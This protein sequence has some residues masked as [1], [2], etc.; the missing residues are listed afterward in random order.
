MMT[1]PDGW[2][3]KERRDPDQPEPTGQRRHYRWNLFLDQLV[4]Q[5]IILAAL[6]FAVF[7]ILAVQSYA[8][9]N[10]NDQASRG[11]GETH[12]IAER[13]QS[14]TIPDGQCYKDLQKSG[15]GGLIRL[16]TY[17]DCALLTPPYPT[18]NQAQLDN[19]RTRAQIPTS[20][21]VPE[22]P[23]QIGTATTV[24]R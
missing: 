8:I 24:T 10:T 9:I 6:A 18:R 11:I 22:P 2:D 21:Q 15:Q 23:P 19:C 16:V 1:D 14:C 12:R 7:V 5:R 13:L 4:E 3:G 20:G 17:W